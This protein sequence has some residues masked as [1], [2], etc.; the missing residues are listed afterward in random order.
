MVIFHSYVK[1]PEGMLLCHLTSWWVCICRGSGL[2]SPDVK[3]DQIRAQIDR[4]WG[5][6]WYPPIR[7]LY[8][9]NHLYV[10]DIPNIHGALK[11]DG[12][13]C[14]WQVIATGI[15]REFAMRMGVC[16]SR[17]M[18]LKLSIFEYTGVTPKWAFQII[19]LW[20]M[21][22]KQWHLGVPFVLTHQGQITRPV[23][24]IWPANH[25]CFG[26]P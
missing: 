26:Y 14:S 15:V 8:I 1:L 17:W 19:L 13:E 22:L 23:P 5:W 16:Y 21:I 25:V 6:L 9:Y 10:Q 7:S 20:A 4:T 18:C 2:A 3:R 11:S 12:A 24:S